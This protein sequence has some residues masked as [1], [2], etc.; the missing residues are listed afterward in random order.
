MDPDMGKLS[1]G[2]CV[3]SCTFSSSKAICRG[4]NEVRV[5]DR[6]IVRMSSAELKDGDEFWGRQHLSALFAAYSL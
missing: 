3:F 4:V 1:R 6:A 2:G 5:G